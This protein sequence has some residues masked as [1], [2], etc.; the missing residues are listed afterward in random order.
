M[1]GCNS[2]WK[3]RV[4]NFL[5]RFVVFC[6]FLTVGILVIVAIE[7]TGN[8]EKQ[9]KSMLLSDL[10]VNMTLKYNL[11]RKEF[12]LLADAI[13]EAKKP[14]PEQWTYGR[15]FSFVIQLVTTVGKL[16]F[17]IFERSAGFDVDKYHTYDTLHNLFL[18]I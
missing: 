17:D 6:A 13:H 10:Q 12:D 18:S 9:K 11:T 14:A 3:Y 5:L 1:S 7:K 8:E 2:T 4:S 15:G 16:E